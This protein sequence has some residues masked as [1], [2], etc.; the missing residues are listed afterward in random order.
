MNLNLVSIVIPAYNLPDYT[1]K[2]LNSII[3][4]SYRPIEVILSDD[5]SPNSLNQIIDKYSN[6]NEKGISY[7]Y[8][9]QSL[10]LG[11]YWNLNFAISKA[12]GKYLLMLDHDDWLIDDNFLYDSINFLEKNTNCNVT[13]SNT[14]NEDSPFPFFNLNTQHWVTINGMSFICNYL[15]NNLHPSRS[16]IIMRFDKLNELNYGNYF[17][18]KE[19][20]QYMPDEAFVSIILLASIGNIA[21][22][23]KIVSIRGVPEKISVSRTKEWNLDTGIKS[24]VQYINLYYYFKKINSIQGMKLMVNLI[25]KKYPI[26]SFNYEIIKGFNFDKIAITLMTASVIRQIVLY[27]FTLFNKIIFKLKNLFFYNIINKIIK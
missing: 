18:S 24:F 23:G 13:I 4:Q 15:F 21:I 16:A 12:T 25:L 3:T 5:N 9:R 19:K 8:Y 14:V 7:K 6:L 26:K 22:S 11:Y 2:T 1:E 17:L 10:N 20:I 27:V